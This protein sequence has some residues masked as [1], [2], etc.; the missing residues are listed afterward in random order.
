VSEM[1][2]FTKEQAIAFAE[3]RIWESWTDEQIANFQMRQEKLCMPFSR[4]HEAVEK[5]LGR[6]VW[7]H[8][9]ADQSR[10]LAE[11]DGVLDAP[12][13]TEIIEMI[14]AEK[15]IIINLQDDDSAVSHA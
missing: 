7:T 11:L 3:S 2:Q 14:P 10:L 5:A 4:F 1:K 6:S 15:R 13:M 12:T 9:F 8:E